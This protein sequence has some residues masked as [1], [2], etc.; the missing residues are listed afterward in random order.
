MCT[1]TVQMRQTP[2]GSTSGWWQSVG[3]FTPIFCA[4]CTSGVRSS[5]SVLMP[6]IVTVTSFIAASSTR[7]PGVRAC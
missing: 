5:A 6:S 4:T 2:Y 1:S 7:E 3:I